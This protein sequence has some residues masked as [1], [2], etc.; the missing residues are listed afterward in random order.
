MRI[1]KPQPKERK[2]VKIP[3]ELRSAMREVHQLIKES[4]A[5]PD[6]NLDFDD[7]IQVEGL[8]G[9]RDKKENKPYVFTF[10][11]ND[12]RE[13]GRWYLTLN[14][15]EIEDIADGNL[16]E[17]EMF[18]CTD[19]NCRTKFREP[20]DSCFY[21]DYY[22]DLNFGTFEFPAATAKLQERG[23]TSL[24]RESTRADVLAALGVPEE[25]GGGIR[26]PDLGFIK[27]WITYRR[28]DCQ[29]R[30]EFD[31]KD[32]V[33]NVTVMERDWEPGK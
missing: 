15:I 10:F 30:F 33:T 27:P 6:I 3:A 29:L 7:A 8:C 31:K 14:E 18:C 25:S 13:R 20:N 16:P 11:P 22:D 32:R 17:I 21:C 28:S 24:S 1:H 26:H 5:D 12:D 19:P 4:L 9:G 23:V 2:M